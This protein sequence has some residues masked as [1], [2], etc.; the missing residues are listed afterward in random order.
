MFS[1]AAAADIFT[2]TCYMFEVY[3]FI[4]ED[5]LLTAILEYIFTYFK[6]DHQQSSQW[7]WK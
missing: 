2:L 5:V 1:P 4:N 6:C 3:L 7:N